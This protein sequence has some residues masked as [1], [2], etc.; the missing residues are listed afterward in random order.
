M[1]SGAVVHLHSVHITKIALFLDR[2]F[3]ANRSATDY[4]KTYHEGVND[5]MF[6]CCCSILT[7]CGKFV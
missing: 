3:P 6:F 5:C 7:K 4:K 2:H 1:L